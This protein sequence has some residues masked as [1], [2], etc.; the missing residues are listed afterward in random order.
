MSIKI[1]GL[2]EIQRNLDRLARN[3]EA[4]DG[5][6]EISFDE[7]FPDAFIR[8]HTNYPSLTAMVDASGM[9]NPEEFSGEAWNAFVI[10]HS[11]FESWE[12]MQQ[13]AVGEWTARKLGFS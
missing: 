2:D 13:E 4:L 7:L 8:R 5:T 11:Q 9:E 12:A 6:H 1:T 3:A 10:A